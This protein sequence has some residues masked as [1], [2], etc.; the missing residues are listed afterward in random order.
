MF[1]K[2]ARAVDHPAGIYPAGMM[3]LL[4]FRWHRII[5]TE[6]NTLMQRTA[7]EN[8]TGLPA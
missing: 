6:L 3:I 7:I 8:A 5:N 2:Q 4:Y 1:L